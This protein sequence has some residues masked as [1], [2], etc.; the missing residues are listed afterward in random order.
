MKLKNST[1]A[2]KYIVESSLKDKGIDAAKQAYKYCNYMDC[3]DT[4]FR[5]LIWFNINQ[6]VRQEIIKLSI[7][8]PEWVGGY[9]DFT[10]AQLLTLLKK[11]INLDCIRNV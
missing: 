5:W 10:G 9:P 8:E 3:K 1:K 7:P 11:A 2:L 6:Q 4:A